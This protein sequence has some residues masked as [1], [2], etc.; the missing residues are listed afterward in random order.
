MYLYDIVILTEEKYFNPKIKNW[1][2]NQVLLEDT[3]L[4]MH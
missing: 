2:I 4:Q 1:Y 3:L